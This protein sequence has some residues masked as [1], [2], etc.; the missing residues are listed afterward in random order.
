[1][2]ERETNFSE[3]SLLSGDSDMNEHTIITRNLIFR[4]IIMDWD[5]TLGFYLGLV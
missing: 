4:V 5:T 3:T 1:M 2:L